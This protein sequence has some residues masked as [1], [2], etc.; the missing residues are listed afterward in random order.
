MKQT[1]Q[2]GMRIA[3]LFGWSGIESRRGAAINVKSEGEGGDVNTGSAREYGLDIGEIA[4]DATVRWRG[5]ISA[6]TEGG[7]DARGS[8]EIVEETFCFDNGEGGFVLWEGRG[9]GNAIAIGGALSVS[10]FIGS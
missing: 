3:C 10:F 9:R 4:E 2:Q 6:E 8:V 7:W 5:V 1:I